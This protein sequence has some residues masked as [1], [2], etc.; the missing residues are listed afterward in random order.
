MS[1]PSMISGRSGELTASSLNA[2]AGRRLAKPPSAARN[3]SRPASGRLSGERELNSLP[4]TAPSKT[5]SASRA[6]ASVSAGSGVP[7]LTM[8]TP[9][10]RLALSSSVWPPSRA[11]SLST[12]TASWVTSGPMP[13]PAVTRIFSFIVLLGSGFERSG[14]KSQRWIGCLSASLP[15][16]NERLL[17]FAQIKPRSPRPGRRSYFRQARSVGGGSI[18]FH[19][20]LVPPG[21]NLFRQQADQILVIDVLLA[22]SQGHKAVV[23]ILQFVAIEGES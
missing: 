14:F 19:H 1:A 21:S 20:C 4:P 3:W 10:M 13:S 23:N 22:V 17:I 9:P 7:S 15:N 11:T 16:T 8:A 2:N 12:E 6:A 5:A 18:Q